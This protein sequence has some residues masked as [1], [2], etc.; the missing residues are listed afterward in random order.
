MDQLVRLEYVDDVLFAGNELNA[1]LELEV[2]GEVTLLETVILS[3]ID[4]GVY[5][6][7]VET[8]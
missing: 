2:D 1:E 3:G 5:E 8:I 7:E 6:L 4:D